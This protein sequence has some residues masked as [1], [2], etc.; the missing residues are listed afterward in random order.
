MTAPDARLRGAIKRVFAEA[1]KALL[2][3]TAYNSLCT[4]GFTYTGISFFAIAEQ[5]LYNDLIAS[6]I[7]IFDDHKDVASLW[8]IIRCQEGVAKTAAAK[9][10]VNL[11]ELRAIVPKLKHV[12][13]KTH[14]H[15]DR[16]GVE[17]PR[18]VWKTAN[19]TGGELTNALNDAA[20]LVAQI[21]K[22]LFEGNLDVSTPYDGSDIKEIIDAYTKARTAK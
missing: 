20:K 19:I 18:E 21:K 1:N 9:C 17:Q 7:R 13:D 11:D 10:G 6:A 4:A 16:K 22:E 8:Y 15:I 12:R 5:A 14:F 2:K 3:R